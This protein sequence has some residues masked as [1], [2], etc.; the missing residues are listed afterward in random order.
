V[1]LADAKDGLRRCTI[2]DPTGRWRQRL[3]TISR[4]RSQNCENANMEVERNKPVVPADHDTNRE[5]A[6]R[7]GQ[8]N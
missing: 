5:M 1:G 8:E 6:E 3:L 7:A 4:L 2:R